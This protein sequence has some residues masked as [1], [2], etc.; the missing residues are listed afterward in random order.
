M[1]LF[2][3]ENDLKESLGNDSPKSTHI[4]GFPFQESISYILS[5][6]YYINFIVDILH[7]RFLHCS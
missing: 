3:L 7:D 5:H 6:Y 1:Y 2:L 4:S